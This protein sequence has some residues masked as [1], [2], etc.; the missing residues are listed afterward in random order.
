MVLSAVM[1]AAGVKIN[2][3]SEG[4]T[5]ICVQNLSDTRLFTTLLQVVVVCYKDL[6][7]FQLFGEQISSLQWKIPN[8]PS[9][10]VHYFDA[11]NIM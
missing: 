11:I 10:V 2:I 9:K 1:C 5:R 7:Y 3:G 6:N 8:R 4:F